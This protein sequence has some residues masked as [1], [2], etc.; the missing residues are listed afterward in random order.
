MKKFIIESA[1]PFKNWILLLLFVEVYWAI[2]QNIRPYLLKLLIDTTVSLAPEDAYTVLLPTAGLLLGAYFLRSIIMSYYLYAWI[3]INPPMKKYIASILT[4]RL[5]KHSKSFFQ[6]QFVGNLSNKVKDVMSSVPDFIRL[7]IG[8]VFGEGLAIVIASVGL[9]S[10]HWSLVLTMV[11][12]MVI[13]SVGSLKLSKNLQNYSRNSAEARSRVIGYIADMLGNIMNIQ[14]FN[15]AR[16][17]R[18]SFKDKLDIYVEANIIRD[19]QIR[20][21]SIFNEFSFL[22]Y[23][24]A[25]ILLLVYGFRNG[26]VSAG[27]FVF[28]L[29]INRSIAQAVR[30][31]LKDIVRKYSELLGTIQQA[32][33]VIYAVINIQD[34]PNATELIVKRGEI[35]FNSVTFSYSKKKELFKDTNL[36]IAPGEKVGLVGSSGSGKSS[37]VNLILRV[38]D[39]EEGSIAIDGQ[40]IK[41]VKLDSLRSQIS[42]IPQDTSLFHRSLMENIRYGNPNASDS[43]VVEAAKKAHAHEFIQRLSSGYDTPVGERGIKLSGGERQRIAIARAI[44]KN[45]PILIIDEATSQLDTITEQEIQNSMYSLMKEKTTLVIAHRLGTLLHMDRILVFESGKIVE[46]GTHSELLMRDGLYASMWDAQLSGFLNDDE[47]EVSVG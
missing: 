32:L 38:H 19:L 31:L 30:V 3:H 9:F 21:L 2:D 34:A 22:M 15:N 44:L 23:Q 24:S 35:R 41:T 40:D 1:K 36:V 28:V 6:N 4:D 12:W 27:D 45:A 14:L 8:N 20:R 16:Y 18:E 37:L 7:I 5:M 11:V 33:D 42:V 13:T 43:D 47:L 17:E 26:S 25:A 46:Q 39:V 29:S 10:I